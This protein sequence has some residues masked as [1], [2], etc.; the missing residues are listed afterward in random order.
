MGEHYENK[1]EL[2]KEVRLKEKAEL[3]IEIIRQ[4]EEDGSYDP[5]DIPYKTQW[6]Q[7]KK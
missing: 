3:R 4:L 2:I 6:L 5:D 7:D 1:T